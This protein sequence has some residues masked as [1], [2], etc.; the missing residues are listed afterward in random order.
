MAFNQGY[1]YPNRIS[2]SG[3]KLGS[4]PAVA[5]SAGGSLLGA[6]LRNRSAKAES[7]RDRAF[8]E[9]M[10]ST[11]YQRAVA[12]MKAAGLNPALAYDQGGASSPGGRAL[13]P[14]DVIGPAV[15]SALSAKRLSE[16]VKNMTAVRKEIDQNI[17]ESVA[18]TRL[19]RQ[20]EAVAA[21]NI[22]VQ[23]QEIAESLARSRLMASEAQLNQA[24]L[25]ARQV[26]GS[27]AA[28]IARIIISGIA[29]VG[30]GVGVGRGIGGMM[31]PK[32]PVVGFKSYG[33]R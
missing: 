8:Q 7:A 23:D 32:R 31:A 14:D 10:S 9:R 16:E 30:L 15:N 12:D 19:T 3:P 21:N 25:P 26:E 13:E 6:Y 1:P 11:S 24:S 22:R 29:G 27:K 17:G 2:I 18:R 4:L 20:Q 28:A 5:I 33:K